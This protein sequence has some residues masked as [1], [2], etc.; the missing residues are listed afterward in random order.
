MTNIR[1]GNTETTTDTR[2]GPGTDITRDEAIRAVVARIANTI[3]TRRWTELGALFADEVTTDYTS[4][5]GGEVVRQSGDD[6]IAAWRQMLSPLDA[7][8]HV[9]G[10]IDVHH[11]G[12]VAIAECNV[13]G[14]HISARAPGGSEWMVAGQWI[15]EM[16]ESGGPESAA[17]WLV[18]R[19]TLRTFYQTGNRDLLAQ[20]AP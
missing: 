6:L 13:R 16:T 17:R 18:T 2:T 11:R 8:Q 14:Y 19:M 7:T 1:T 10:A 9:T 20:T 4:L 3:D 12:S 15:I 5:F